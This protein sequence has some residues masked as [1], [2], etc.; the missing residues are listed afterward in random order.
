M[1]VRD[2]PRRACYAA[3]LPLING[4]NKGTTSKLGYRRRWHV[5]NV[6]DIVLDFY[7]LMEIMCGG[8]LYCWGLL[9][10]VVRRSAY[11]LL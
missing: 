4:Y 7:L 6:R 3:R 2:A 1:T 11:Y 10:G 8:I 9:G 5:F